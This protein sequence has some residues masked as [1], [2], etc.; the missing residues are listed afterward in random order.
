MLEVKDLSKIYKSK[1]KNGV[2][3]HAL[4][5]VSLCFPEKGMVFLLG[6][7]GSGKSTLLNV[8]GGLDAPTS[9]EVIVK[10]RSS[11]N[12][13]QSDFDSYRNTYVGFIFQEYNVLNEFTVEDNIALAL[14][15]Q[16]KPKDKKAIADLL[17]QVDL[18]GFAKRK[19]NTLSGGQKQRIAIARAL[20]KAPE[21]IMADE[22]TGALDSATGKQV[23]DTL[24]KLSRDKLVIVVSHDRE[25]AEIYADRIIELKDGKILSDVSKT[26]EKQEEISPNVTVIGDILCIKQ[27]QDLTDEEFDRIKAMIRRN[28]GDVII[29]GNDQDVQNFKKVNRI[30]DDG[31]KEVF[32]D[33]D[34][35]KI[36]I[37]AYTPEES[38]FI[39]SK[40]PAKHAAKI[41]VSGLKTK[42]IR[43]FFTILLCVV[44]F[45]LFGVLS[46][47]MF[48]NNESMFKTTLKDSDRDFVVFDKVYRAENVWYENGQSTGS[49][50]SVG[51]AK[52][53]TKE[54]KELTSTF[55]EGAF[56]ALEVSAQVSLRQSATYYWN[57]NIT[58][59]AYMSEN[60]FTR[61]NMMGDYPVAEDEI[62]VSSYLADMIVACKAI[63]N[64]GEA[65]DASDRTQLIGATIMLDGY[66]FKITGI[67]DSGVIDPKFDVL[68]EG[69]G[70]EYSLIYE[71][72]SY[73]R[74]GTYQLI[75]VSEEGLEWFSKRNSYMYSDPSD[76]SSNRWGSA[77]MD[78]GSDETTDGEE[79]KDNMI[80]FGDGSIGFIQMGSSVQYNP[81]SGLANDAYV[82]L[83]GGNKTLAKN[84]AIISF[85]LLAND[86]INRMYSERNE[87][88]DQMYSLEYLVS[89]KNDISY[90]ISYYEGDIQTY[91]TWI[92]EAEAI[93]ATLSEEDWEYWDY[94]SNIEMWRGERDYRQSELDMYQSEYNALFT[95]L[96][97]GLTDVTAENCESK[98]EAMR[99]RI[100]AYDEQIRELEAIREGQRT[101]YTEVEGQD[102]GETTVQ[103]YT[104]EERQELL[105]KF[106]KANPTYAE[107]LIVKFYLTSNYQTAVTETT[108][109][110]VVGIV[111]Q[112]SVDGYYV[113]DAIWFADA[114]VD[115][116]WEIQRVNMSYHE[117]KTNYRNEEGALYT[118]LYVPYNH[119]DAQTNFLWDVYNSKDY[120][121]DDSK[122]GLVGGY[123]NALEMIDSFVTELSTIFLY[124]GLVLAAFAI[125][126]FSNF[127]SV[128][129]SQKRREIGILRAVGARSVDVFKIF[130]SESLVIALICSA[131]AIAGS[132]VV[133]QFLNAEVGASLGASIF[134]FG[135][136]SV[137]V[138]LA[139]ALLTALLATFLPVRTAAKK[140]PVDSIR[141]L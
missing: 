130:F 32:R 44:S 10:G 140:K 47:L 81:V 97:E 27:G 109:Y 57:S 115:A 76:N 118:K 20:V 122:I 93:L 138:I 112:E 56:G 72:E 108:D 25:F 68:R 100:D 2:D 139:I 13:S 28:A 5:H 43:L 53:S 67:F 111:I 35:K 116:Y 110:T 58:S 62:C 26:Q 14:E 38:R 50:Q 99:T 77:Y 59:A 36:D 60:A 135:L 69:T 127:I 86:L 117:I 31:E 54:M 42:P 21:I 141:A 18:T 9:G 125:L 65:I 1:Q 6:K 55:G 126:L 98:L 88:Q 37:K 80:H 40:L 103:Y 52:F 92:A 4:D 90:Q 3:T 129:I 85:G 91:N 84:E 121:E 120:A 74:D 45:V 133:C 132:S 79:M 94:I 30:T 7:S 83:V 15:L 119:S 134:V 71:F 34:E 24:K 33:T 104:L 78:D 106:F 128:S 73:L 66:A 102:E 107:N 64:K 114:V 49:Y 61:Q 63:D 41:G 70:Q 12:F 46:T 96:P 136:M 51:T 75:G 113:N 17:E 123:I 39:R 87:A 105:K 23:F 11:K 29:A 22:P 8:C 48:Y 131:L 16:G 137:L 82:S 19:P 89:R 95:D 124:I 101:F